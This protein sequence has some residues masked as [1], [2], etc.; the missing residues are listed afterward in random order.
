[1]SDPRAHSQPITFFALLFFACLLF[2]GIADAAPSIAL[3]KKSGPPTSGI[4]VSGTGFEPNVG[5]DIYFDTKNEALVV[6]NGKGEFDKAGIHAPR[7]ARPGQHWVS[8]LERNNDKGA[9]EPFLVQTD[10]S[11]FGFTPNGGRLNNYENVLNPG[12]VGTLEL[13]WTYVTGG[14]FVQ[15][16]P[17]V[18]N[19]I[20][21]IVTDKLYALDTRTGTNLWTFAISGSLSS[22]AVRKGVLYVG[23]YSDNKLYA[24]NARTGAKLWDYTVGG[25]VAC[26]P[27]VADGVV[28]FGSD[29]HNLYALNAA[30]GVLKW[31]YATGGLVRSAPALASGVVYVGSDDHNLYALDMRT[32]TKLWSYTTDGEIFISAPATQDGVVYVASCGVGHTVYALNASTGD[33][34]WNYITGDGIQASLAVERGV[35]YVASADGYLYALAA[36]T[37]HKLWSYSGGF[38][39]SSPAAANGVIYIGSSGGSMD[40][41]NASTGALLWSYTTG[42]DFQYASPVVADGLVYSGSDVGTI[43]AFGLLGRAQQKQDV[44][45]KPNFN[46]LRPDF[47]LKV[48]KPDATL[49]SAE[50]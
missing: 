37:G 31:S 43:Y 11:Q 40:A 15:S 20:V 39:T 8:A 19:G 3:S 33:L 46:M 5:V 13:K 28:Y 36:T 27:T 1:M 10:W 26:P 22:P 32:G 16:S 38:Y 48:P 17:A 29:D 14:G 24:L 50:R 2:C 47:N 41:I 9:Q 34:L 42:T 49:T 25:P 44:A 45:S 21:Y 4:L 35:V 23:S 6:T 12:N 7:S 30:T 18:E